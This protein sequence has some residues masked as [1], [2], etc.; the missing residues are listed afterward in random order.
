MSDF[1]G[2]VKFRM[3]KMVM[4]FVINDIDFVINVLDRIDVLLIFFIL[5][6][7]NIVSLVFVKF[8]FRV[9]IVTSSFIIN[10][11]RHYIVGLWISKT[12]IIDH[13]FYF[14]LYLES[15]LFFYSLNL[16]LCLFFKI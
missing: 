12:G 13:S 7:F 1:T 14:I 8:L 10:H 9:S 15:F 11:M 6:A 2:F 16:E 3:N 4:N 5:F